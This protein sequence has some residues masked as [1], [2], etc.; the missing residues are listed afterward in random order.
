V[1]GQAGAGI[2]ELID[3]AVGME[4]ENSVTGARTTQVWIDVLE[5]EFEC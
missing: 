1:T 5:G 2:W 3:S 4:W